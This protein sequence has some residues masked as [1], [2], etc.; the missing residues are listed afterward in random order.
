[1]LCRTSL[2]TNCCIHLGSFCSSTLTLS[3]DCPSILSLPLHLPLLFRLFSVPSLFT[4]HSEFHLPV[5]CK[6]PHWIPKPKKHLCRSHCLTL[7]PPPALSHCVPNRWKIYWNLN[8]KIEIAASKCGSSFPPPYP[9]THA[10]LLSFLCFALL[11]P[12]TKVCLAL[13]PSLS[14]WLAV[15][16]YA[17]TWRIQIHI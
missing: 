9:F 17:L 3:F 4:F 12:H 15:N 6:Y 14:L 16:I 8:F 10:L 1:M 11:W 7:S 2:S 13:P 5:L